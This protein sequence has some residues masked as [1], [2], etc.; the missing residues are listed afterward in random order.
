MQL[1]AAQTMQLYTAYV[2]YRY[3]LV[4]ALGMSPAGLVFHYPLRCDGI[5]AVPGVNG[6]ESTPH[7][8]LPHTPQ[9]QALCHASS[10]RKA[11]NMIY[12]EEISSE[13][14]AYR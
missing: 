4:D 7:M 2:Q 11:P 5:A 1:S 3:F 13:N 6:S 10:K 14:V 9:Q 12:S 8:E